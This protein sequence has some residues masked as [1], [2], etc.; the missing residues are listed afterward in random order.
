[1]NISAKEVKSLRDATGAGM[2][3]CKK[4]LI[5]ME[6]DLDKA[7]DHLRKQGIAKASKRTGRSTNEGLIYSYVHNPEGRQPDGHHF[8][9]IGV[10]LEVNCETDFVAKTEDY[11][12][13]CK[14]I[15]VHIVGMNPLFVSRE[16]V[17]S[18]FIEKEKEIYRAQMENEK[19]PANIIERIIEGKINKYLQETCLLEQ[20]FIKDPDKTVE[21]VVK[22]MMAKTGE[23]VQIS[24]FIRFQ[25]G[26][27]ADSE[28]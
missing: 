11:R 5:E 21:D 9:R 13:F 6:G 15:S 18:D 25:L 28:E 16:K 22:E 27:G 23:N 24:R 2:M 14:N 26:E 19:K 8:G 3:D 10:L 20:A 4:A 12:S 1:M 7:V 17:A